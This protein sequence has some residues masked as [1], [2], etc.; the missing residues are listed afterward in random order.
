[1]EIRD[2]IK[3]LVR[4][5]GKFLVPNPENWRLHP[6]AQIQAL[7]G[8][9][10]AVGI[11]STCAVFEVSVDDVDEG[12]A[13][14]PAFADTT[15]LPVGRAYMLIDGHMRQSQHPEVFWPCEVLDLNQDEARVIL[16]T[17]DPLGAMAKTDDDALR[18]LHNLAAPSLAG[19]PGFT[20]DAKPAEINQ[21]EDVAA[22]VDIADDLLAKWGVESGQLWK[23]EGKQTH[24]LL[25]GSASKPDDI[26][27]LNANDVGLVFTSP[28]YAQQREYDKSSEVDVQDW[29]GLMSGVFANLPATEST[30]VLVSLGLVH[31]DN[32]W[33]PYWEEWIGFM[34]RSGWR[35]FGWYVWD[36]MH[37]LPGSWNGRLSPSFEFVFHFNKKAAIP[38][39][40]VPKKPENVKAR[41]EGQSTMRG[42]DGRTKSFSNP[43]ASA[44]A[45]KAPDSVIR[46]QRQHGGFPGHPAPFSVSF[47]EFFI[48]SWHGQVFDPFMGSGTTMLA[49]EQ[50]GRKC[51]GVEISPKYCAVILQRMTDAGCTC[52]SAV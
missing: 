49:A 32:E 18:A 48:R 8:V 51:Y 34:R 10:E 27:K 44:S 36:Q 11:A 1:M 52:S 29:T 21:V 41:S 30:Q 28:P 14:H 2:R 46:V 25:C 40:W 3:D 13:K 23:I 42:S 4:V 39:K 20:I 15:D 7:N 17:L 37:G 38:A 47:A 5:Q 50:L 45:N 35:R 6:D 26:A 33:I 43:A 9:L 24:Y 22:K 12:T 16:R 19:I 31:R